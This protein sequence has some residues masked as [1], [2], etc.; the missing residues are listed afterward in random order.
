MGTTESKMVSI[1]GKSIPLTKNGLPNQVYLSKEAK[2]IVKAFNQKIAEK[3]QKATEKELS[4]LYNTL[5]L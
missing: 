5:G 1:G 3:K 2:V 4:D